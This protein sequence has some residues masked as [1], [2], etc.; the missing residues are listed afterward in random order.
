MDKFDV[1]PI[2]LYT[3]VSDN[4]PNV[5]SSIRKLGYILKE[6]I[7]NGSSDLLSAE[8]A[9]VE[10]CLASVGSQRIVDMEAMD[11]AEMEEDGVESEDDQVE[12]NI[13]WTEEHD[14]DAADY[15][16]AEYELEGT[17]CAAHSC[18]L[19]V[20]DVLK[21]S[22]KR[23]DIIKK[24]VKNTRLIKYRETFVNE[25]GSFAPVCNATRWNAVFLMLKALRDQRAFYLM[26]ENKFGE[27]GKITLHFTSSHSTLSV[28]P[29]THPFPILKG[30]STRKVLCQFK[31]S[32]RLTL[33]N[34]TSFFFS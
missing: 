11:E 1:R 2:Q 31:L 17:R 5:N 19:A 20:W 13:A 24:L 3:V 10:L 16:E 32:S 22:T 29:P 4:A 14:A 7:E 8:L 12:E 6:I 27:L 9:E 25:K 34:G 26:L 30:L 21:A 33:D 28:F 18:Q 23:I 15:N